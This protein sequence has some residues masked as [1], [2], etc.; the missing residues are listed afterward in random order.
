M[1]VFPHLQQATSGFALEHLA[2]RI[3]PPSAQIPNVWRDGISI[4]LINSLD[5][6]NALTEYQSY[7]FN[8][9]QIGGI[10]GASY[11][12]CTALRAFD[13]ALE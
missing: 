11:P 6:S 13:A 8:F 5:S 1:A 4:R 10:D 7:S 2:R 12:N 3:S 9:T